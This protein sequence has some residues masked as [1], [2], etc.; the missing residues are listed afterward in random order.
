MKTLFK[1]A[2]GLACAMTVMACSDGMNGD[3][4][5]K[6]YPVELA[7]TDYVLPEGTDWQN[8]KRDS[9]Y[10]FD[11]KE[12]LLP[13]ISKTDIPEIDFGQY[14]LLVVSGANDSGIE[15]ISIQLQ[16]TEKDSY[17]LNITIQSTATSA[18]RAWNMAGLAPKLD[19]N[20]RI[21]LNNYIQTEGY[22]VGYETC[23]LNIQNKT[24]IAKG[25]IFISTNLKDTLAV[26][27]MPTDIYAF[28]EE[29]FPKQHSG[30]I[31]ASFPEQF[32]YA[33]KIKLTY[34]LSSWEELEK[35][36][37]R[38]SCVIPSI[39]PIRKTYNNSIPVIVKSAIK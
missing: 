5:I 10:L 21:T 37:L 26:Y 25:Y 13:Y 19:K 6:S 18:A 28:P 39:Y 30:V 12:A 1:A 14:T 17:R 34:A 15:N 23:G 29:A 16:Q 4:I 32:R 22:I 24:G 35:L 8:L 2:I 20:V 38:E 9:V 33:F 7:M 36:G 11:S 31:N 27:N 3:D